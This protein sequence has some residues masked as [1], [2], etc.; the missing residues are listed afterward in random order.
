MS[1]ES[2]YIPKTK[3]KQEKKRLNSII[4]PFITIDSFL[5][6]ICAEVKRCTSIMK[7]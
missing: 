5:A 4:D 3:S 6:A 2:T 1:F 7:F